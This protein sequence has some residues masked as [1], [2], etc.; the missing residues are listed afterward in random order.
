M[1]RA[2]NGVN[3]SLLTAIISRWHSNCKISYY[4][5]PV[6]TLASL[7]CGPSVIDYQGGSCYIV[8][9]GIHPKVVQDMLGHWTIS[10]TL[11]T[12]SH[13]LPNMQKEAV[14]GSRECFGIISV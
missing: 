5:K 13:V 1:I 3:R 9:K 6:Q 4:V 14:K 2:P 11:D 12:Y 7:H 8:I 10:I